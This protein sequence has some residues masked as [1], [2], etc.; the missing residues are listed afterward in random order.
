MITPHTIDAH[1]E[2]AA[3]EYF[4]K[5]LFR[6]AFRNDD[7]TKSQREMQ[8]HNNNYYY[9]SLFRFIS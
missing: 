2:S 9:Y 3:S 4:E 6:H 8:F 7:Y 1:L 5:G